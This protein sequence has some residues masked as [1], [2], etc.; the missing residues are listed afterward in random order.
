MNTDTTI[1]LD[2]PYVA[3]STWS[4]TDVTAYSCGYAFR[5]DVYLE[6]AKLAA[7]FGHDVSAALDCA[8]SEQA[9]KNLLLQFSGAWAFIARRASGE[10]IAATDVIR[11][12]PIFFTCNSGGIALAWSSYPLL[13]CLDCARIDESSAAQ[14]FLSGMVMGNGTLF[15]GVSQLRLGEFLRYDPRKG[16]EPRIFRYFQYLPDVLFDGT[17]EEMQDTLLRLLDRIFGRYRS[18]FGDAHIVVPVSGGLDSRLLTAM[19]K[20]HDFRNVTCISYGRRDSVET[21]FSRQTAESIGYKWRFLEFSEGTWQKWSQTSHMEG[22]WD[23]SCRGVAIPH[24]QELPA[25]EE[26]VSERKGDGRL[27]FMPGHT[28]LDAYRTPWDLVY[29][30][31]AATTADLMNAILRFRFMLWPD[32][33]NKLLPEVEEQLTKSFEASDIRSFLDMYA[34]HNRWCVENRESKFIVNSAR[35]YEFFGQ[36]WA[37]PLWDLDI[38][39]FSLTMPIR[40]RWRKRL[41]ANTLIDKVCT[42]PLAKLADVPRTCYYGKPT[43]AR[44]PEDD[45]D[46]QTMVPPE[47]PRC[48]IIK[49]LASRIAL[50]A[51]LNNMTRKPPPA[52]ILLREHCFSLGKDPKDVH[53][54]DVLRHYYAQDLPR[55]VRAEL[56][57]H[58]NVPL[59][60]RDIN[61]I[62]TPIMLAREYRRAQSAGT[63]G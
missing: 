17:E 42:G 38:A 48:G 52:D 21:E 53:L 6:G 15:A 46:V 32:H 4:G 35:A 30:G 33:H 31:D 1:I 12:F 47:K 26:L 55:R 45:L 2:D 58:A 54:S 60:G 43:S 24:L 29:K 3:W 10:I 20:R 34:Q 13:H 41:L 50:L 51:W 19:L 11:S 23:Y 44:V 25:I 59:N 14:F 49:S 56:R 63:K 39:R 27:I 61:S 37:L 8:D 5:G 28:A 57:L 18:V 36:G 7:S 16:P 9:I 22:Y 40:L 62:L